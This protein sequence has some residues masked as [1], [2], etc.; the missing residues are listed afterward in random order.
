M[1][2]EFAALA[3]GLGHVTN[4]A[5]TLL[6]ARDQ[7]E[8]DALRIELGGAI[9][10]TQS[11]MHEVQALYGK[12]L[13]LNESL[14]KQLIAYDHGEQKSARY[15]LQELAPGIVAYTIK[16]DAAPGEPKHWLCPTCYDERKT[17]ILHLDSPGSDVWE[18]PRGCP[19]IITGER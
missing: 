3:T 8:R 13:E 19:H 11:K 10:E 6:D 7:A 14:K 17:S 16:P 12:Q 9:L 2:L 18:C 1:L 15:S 4:I 5:K